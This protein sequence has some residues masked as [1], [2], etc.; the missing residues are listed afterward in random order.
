MN[1]YY[2]VQTSFSFLSRNHN[3]VA[4]IFLKSA[5]EQALLLPDAINEVPSCCVPYLCSHEHLLLDLSRMRK[6]ITVTC[7]YVEK[8]S[9]NE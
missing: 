1:I 7:F 8:D 3:Y 9:G 2:Q 5:S 6:R 4:E